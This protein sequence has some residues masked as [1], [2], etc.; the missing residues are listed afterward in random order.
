MELD[1][2]PKLWTFFEERDV[3]IELNVKE[4]MT[5]VTAEKSKHFSFL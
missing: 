1:L 5:S 2:F 3:Y 4:T